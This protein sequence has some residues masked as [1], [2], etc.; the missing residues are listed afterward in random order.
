MHTHKN[1]V[2]ENFSTQTVT[3]KLIRFLLKGRKVITIRNNR[4]VHTKAESDNAQEVK[5]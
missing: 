1:P 5:Y 3:D 2:A 4:Q